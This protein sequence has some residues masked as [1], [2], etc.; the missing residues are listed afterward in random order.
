MAPSSCVTSVYVTMRGWMFTV[1]SYGAS[2]SL[3]DPC[4]Y[5]SMSNLFLFTVS[6][7]RLDQ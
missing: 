2:R 5:N 6:A 4:F 3:S 1:T 7:R